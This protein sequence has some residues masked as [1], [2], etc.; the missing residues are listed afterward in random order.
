MKIQWG[1]IILLF[2]TLVACGQT[3]LSNRTWPSLTA[4]LTPEELAEREAE[5]EQL[6]AST[7]Q[8]FL[9]WRLDSQGGSDSGKLDNPADASAVRTL[10]RKWLTSQ[11]VVATAG[12]SR[13]TG[14]AHGGRTAPPQAR[15]V[16]KGRNLFVAE[17]TAFKASVASELNTKGVLEVVTTTGEQLR[18]TVLGLVLGAWRRWGAASWWPP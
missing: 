11:P 2:A 5:V 8:A 6:A 17:N 12:D 7:N 16:A 13:Q 1:G 3:N 10:F 18:S 15:W 9:K 14:G 4:T